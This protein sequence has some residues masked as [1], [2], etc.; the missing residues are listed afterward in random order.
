MKLLTDYHHHALAES[1][2]LLGERLGWDVYFPAG[3]DWFTS[4]TWQFEKV[5]HGDRVA[6]Q[7]LEGIWAGAEPQ[8]SGLLRHDPRHLGRIQRGISHAEAVDTDWDII[9]S[10]L[11]ANDVGFHALAKSKGAAFGVQVG[12]NHQ[13]SDW[14]RADFILSSSTLPQA[15]FV[16]PDTWGKRLTFQGKPTVI[17]HQ[18]FSLDTFHE[19]WPPAEANTVA[20]FVNCYPEGPSYPAFL[21]FARAHPDLA[22][23]KVYGATGQP[24]WADPAV[25]YTDEFQRGDIGPVPDVAD[26]MR[27]A[28]LIWHTKHWS[29]GFGHTIHNAFAVGRPVLGFQRYYQDKFAGPL[30]QEGVTSYDIEHLDHADLAA[31]IHRLIRD[32]ERHLRMSQ[33]A[34][35][36]FRDLVDFD[37]EADAIQAM[38]ADIVA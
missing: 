2:L 6:R 23:F 26:A 7:Y 19:Q 15:G 18:E 16:T 32:D 37:G 4:D 22:E 27:A 24:S 11:P 30:W 33:A 9:L 28:R 13:E 34:A 12:N 36:R 31:L 20:S 5:W 1:L 38:L 17:Y 3:M 25:P 8:G 10:T 14:G 35:A 21:E 29:D